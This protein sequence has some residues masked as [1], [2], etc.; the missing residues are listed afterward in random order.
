[1][2][3]I[4]YLF[5][6]FFVI[7]IICSCQDSVDDKYTKLV[8]QWNGKTIIFPEDLVFTKF[9]ADTL[10]YEIPKS[11]YKIIVITDSLDCMSCKLQ[12][13]KWQEFIHHVDSLTNKTIPFLFFFQSTDKNELR[14]MLKQRR[15]DQIICLDNKNK[16]YLANKIRRNSDSQ[17][18][19]LD[20]DN[21]IILIG[22]PIEN[23]QINRLYLKEICDN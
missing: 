5:I 9:I 17:S 8:K 19:L 10:T 11:K 3:N 16:F 7:S 4:K 6:T 1:M 21:R 18:F 12:L 15:F 13:H 22:N 23:Y 20:S 14:Y 2:N